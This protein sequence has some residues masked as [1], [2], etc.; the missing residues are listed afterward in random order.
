[1]ATSIG[2]QPTNSTVRTHCDRLYTPPG[3]SVTRV[4]TQPFH[5]AAAS[6]VLR[7][8]PAATHVQQWGTYDWGAGSH[9]E[10]NITRQFIE[11]DLRDDD[12]IS[13]LSLTL[14]FA[15]SLSLDGLGAGN[16]WFEGA[17]AATLVREQ[18]HDR[19]AFL[20]VADAQAKSV[21]LVHSYV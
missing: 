4:R 9:F 3:M 7:M 16:I 13:Q 20:A 18:M 6:S 1:M 19:P 11:A 21:E 14:R 17:R 8:L 15:P 12:A 2:S 5:P 10:L